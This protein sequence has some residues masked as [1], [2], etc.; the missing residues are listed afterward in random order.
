[1]TMMWRD[2]FLKDAG[3]KLFSLLLAVLIWGSIWSGIENGVPLRKSLVNPLK[4]VVSTGVPQVSEPIRRPVAVM[5]SPSDQHR[6]RV[7]PPLVTL[8]VQGDSA[9]LQGL[10]E[11]SI[12]V[13]VDVA[14]FEAH[15][16]SMSGSVACTVQ[17]QAPPG[18][19]PAKT[20]PAAVLVERLLPPATPARPTNSKQ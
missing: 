18:I 16:D 7:T 1:M 17:V 19:I 3:W 5:R 12:H 6:Y 20:E 14:D 2:Y 4:P 8:V 13:F 9:R 11:E 15:P 10:D